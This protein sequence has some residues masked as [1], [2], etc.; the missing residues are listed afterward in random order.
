MASFGSRRRRVRE[1]FEAYCMFGNT[2]GTG[3]LSSKNFAKLAK[4]S[5]LLDTHRLTS[6]NLD[7]I[8]T[9]HAARGAKKLTWV[10]FLSALEECAAFKGIEVEDVHALV[11]NARG[12]RL[13]A[14]GP[15]P[16]RF[17]DDK[18]LYT[19]THK[20]AAIDRVGLEGHLDRTDADAKKRYAREKVPVAE[21]YYGRA[22]YET[23]EKR[24]N[25]Y[26][27]LTRYL[28]RHNPSKAAN[29]GILLARY[30][31][32]ED[33]LFAKIEAKYGEPVLDRAPRAHHTIYDRLTDTSL[34]TGAHRQRFDDL[35]RGRGL[36]GRDY[37][38]KTGGVPARSPSSFDGNTNGN[39]D[40]VFFDSS[41]FLMR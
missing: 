6:T 13:N 32:R 8:W 3:G 25:Y 30:V 34:Y 17:H 5:E 19:G 10:Q 21:N 12:P 1:R 23:P 14:S 31:G 15:S 35:G 39:S 29:V 22:A 27:L 2:V 24:D 26:E 11:A 20:A 38:S 40:T 36:K 4:E 28:M 41:Q 9:R 16:V 33:E 18:S 37:T 7:L